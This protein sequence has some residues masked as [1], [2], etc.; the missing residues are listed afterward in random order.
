MPGIVGSIDALIRQRREI[1]RIFRLIKKNLVTKGLLQR[2]DPKPSETRQYRSDRALNLQ[3]AD[4]LGD[5]AV[6]VA[7]EVLYDSIPDARQ[8]CGVDE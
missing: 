8:A 4:Y 3:G 6:P 7:L 2:P 5:G 1:T